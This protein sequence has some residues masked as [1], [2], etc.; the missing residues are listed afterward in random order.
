MS[1]SEHDPA[2]TEFGSDPDGWGIGDGERSGVGVRLLMRAVQVYTV[3]QGRTVT[4]REAAIAFRCSDIMIRAAVEHH[5]WMFIEGPVD[6][7][8]IQTI[9]HD[10]E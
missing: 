7:P 10:G 3:M 8:W 4:V 9:E 1:M 2:H 5:P 6:A